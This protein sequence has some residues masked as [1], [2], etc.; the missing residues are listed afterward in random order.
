MFLVPYSPMFNPIE[1]CFSEVKNHLKKELMKKVGLDQ[2]LEN[3]CK[4]I[5]AENCQSQIK[6]S[7]FFTQCFQERPIYKEVDLVLNDDGY[8]DSNL[9][10]DDEVHVAS[11]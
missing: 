1:E 5:T 3:S 9:G 6:H 7:T 2:A 8:E 10:S 11:P 4:T